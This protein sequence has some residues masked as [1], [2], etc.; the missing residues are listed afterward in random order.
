MAQPI[1]SGRNELQRTMQVD[2]FIME[3]L[4]NCGLSPNLQIA[5]MQS[6]AKVSFNI[7]FSDWIN[8]G[9]PLFMVDKIMIPLKFGQVSYPMPAGTFKVMKSELS[10]ITYNRQLGGTASSNAGGNADNAFD[11]DP[12]TACVQTSPGGAIQ[13]E[14][15]TTN[16]CISY[17]GIQSNINV[18]SWNLTFQ[19]S[20]DG[21]EW[22]T[23]QQTNYQQYL[24]GQVSWFVIPIFLNVT[25][26]RVLAGENDTLNIQE[27]YFCTQGS[28]N[29]AITPFSRSE[30][31]KLANP[32]TIGNPGNYYVNEALTPSISLYPAPSGL[33]Q[34]MLVD[35]SFYLNDIVNLTDNVQIP[36]SFYMPAVFGLAKLLSIKY[37]PDRTQM[38]N[39]EYVQSLGTAMSK[40]RENVNVTIRPTSMGLKW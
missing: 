28:I 16:T 33:Y 5:T 7:L 2:N 30:D 8:R 31:I 4:E 35:R 34:A 20:F 38:L 39:A 18:S 15:P 11:N 13:Y 29:R 1:Y 23:A 19:Y 3:A 21:T 27:I 36:Q 40:N 37:A 32:A 12:T 24:A 22:L 17:V 6:S 26:M 14:F 9:L 10:L 25:F